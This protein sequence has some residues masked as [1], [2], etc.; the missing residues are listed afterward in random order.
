MKTQQASALSVPDLASAA[1]VLAPRILSAIT[2]AKADSST[3][4]AAGRKPSTKTKALK[5]KPVQRN[6]SIP[7]QKA[8]EKRMARATNAARTGGTKKMPPST[9]KNSLPQL[10]LSD[11]A[12]VVKNENE[13][14]LTVNAAFT[15]PVSPIL[16]MHEDE[17]VGPGTLV[18]NETIADRHNADEPANAT[19]YEALASATMVH[20]PGSS[21]A[22][23]KQTF[24]QAL[25]LQWTAL[26]LILTRAWNWTQHKLKSHQV[27]KRLRVCESVSLGE[28]R[29]IAVIQ[30]D[31]EQFLVGGSSSSVST[32]AHLEPRREFSEV[33]RNRC[34]QDLSQA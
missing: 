14:T 16:V 2:T 10:V 3:G 20:E 13:I 25:A 9:A 7:K 26:F 27:K 1:T 34:E 31:G 17:P 4:T 24:L 11:K 8:A 29:F 32:L 22:V 12:S 33:F 28:K 30:V 5:K 18:S 21:P 23:K 19:E 15:K 6:R